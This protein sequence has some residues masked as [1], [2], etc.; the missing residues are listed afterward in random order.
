MTLEFLNSEFAELSSFK[1]IKNEK[2]LVR[3]IIKLMVSRD[4]TFIKYK[5]KEG[6]E[7]LKLHPSVRS[8]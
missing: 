1:E 5:D 6:N 2:K 4:K 7:V 8:F 3:A